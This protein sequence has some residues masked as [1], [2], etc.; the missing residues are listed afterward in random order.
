MVEGTVNALPHVLKLMCVCKLGET[1]DNLCMYN[2][3]YILI[4][5][6]YAKP[7]GRETS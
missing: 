3:I 5:Y 6:K 2:N 7:H 4:L 1:S